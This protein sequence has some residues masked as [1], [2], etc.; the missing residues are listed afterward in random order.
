MATSSRCIV[1]GA[2]AGG[3]ETLKEV[4]SVLPSDIPAAIFVVLHIA[5][6]APS[7]LPAILSN[8]SSLEAV[9]PRDGDEIRNG[10][11]YVAPPDHHLLIE[12]NH[13][14][15]K[16]GPKENRFRPSIDALFRSAAYA[17][18][19]ASIGVVLSG[20]L[21]DGT[22]GLWTIQRLGGITIIQDPDQSRYEAM[23]RNALEYV[24]PDYKLPS[25]KIARLL[26]DLVRQTVPAA[27]NANA[28]LERRI[29]V[30]VEIAAGKSP[31]LADGGIYMGELTPFTCPECHGT[32]MKVTEGKLSRFRCHTGHAYSDNALLE[33]VMESSGLMMW[34]IV[35][36]M[37]ESIMLLKHM[38]KHLEDTGASDRAALY[39][40]KAHEIEQKH[41]MFY[42]EVLR[43][44]SLSG[45]NLK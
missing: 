40:E 25:L 19:P 1:L 23:P 31:E 16:R 28:D 41:K 6:A 22:S 36:S 8:N 27:T 24:E 3:V 18:G 12:N 45:D 35:R 32:L 44:E 21:D 39:L 26:N 10:L 9:H 11:I 33:A 17:Y 13:I 5:P 14:A 37:E 38:G 42:Q 20:L 43:H 29:A 4:L 15:V 7:Y 30:E 2:S 34:Q